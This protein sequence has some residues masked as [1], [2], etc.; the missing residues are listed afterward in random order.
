M[1][2]IWVLHGPNL[3]LLGSREED[4][5]GKMR[6]SDM[7]EVME[8]MAEDLGASL[9]CYQDNAEHVLIDLI[10]QAKTQDV[11]AIIFNPAAFTHTSI[12][13]RDALL[14]VKIP[15][16]EVHMS[17]IFAREPFRKHSYFS[18]I[19]DGVFIGMGILSY[20]LALQAAMA[21]IEANTTLS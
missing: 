19:A 5:Y 13:L 6:L 17:N 1:N 8:D 18:D 3:N 16:F 21:Y 2:K 20:T 12:A 9:A 4:T 11:D 10:H 14:A 15:F 7:N